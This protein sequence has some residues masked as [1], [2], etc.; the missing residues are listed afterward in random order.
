MRKKT[1][2]SFS[3]NTGLPEFLFPLFWEYEPE[4]IDIELHANIIMERIMERGSWVSMVWLKKTYT[5]D[6]LVSFLEKRGKRILPTRELNY[7]AIMSGVSADKRKNWLRD[8]NERHDVW[9]DR[10]SH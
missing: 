10:H 2:N 7:W 8:A 6:Q 5:K 4:N 9:R 1:Q 3:N